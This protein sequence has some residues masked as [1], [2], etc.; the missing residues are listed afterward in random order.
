LEDFEEMGMEVS[1]DPWG[2]IWSAVEKGTNPNLRLIREI[3]RVYHR[4]GKRNVAESLS[5]QPGKK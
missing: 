4:S 5:G 1:P 3:K 2:V